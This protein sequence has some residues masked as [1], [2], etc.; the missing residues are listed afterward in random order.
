MS[1]KHDSNEWTTETFELINVVPAADMFAVYA[2]PHPTQEGKFYLEEDRIHFLGIAKV[3]EHTYQGDDHSMLS[4]LIKTRQLPNRVVGLDLCEGYF[5]V[6][7]EAD[8]FAGLMKD[9]DDIND[10]TGCLSSSY[11]LAD[12]DQANE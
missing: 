7:D 8:N 12:E 10:A 1:V 5:S 6:C 4:K 3:N 11:P 9:G 2:V